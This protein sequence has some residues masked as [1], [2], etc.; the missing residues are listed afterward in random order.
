MM[1]KIKREM[2]EEIDALNAELARVTEVLEGQLTDA[3]EYGVVTE[4]AR[5]QQQGRAEAAEALAAQ[6]ATER[7]GFSKD[8]SKTQKALELETVQREQ[9][10]R[11]LDAEMKQAAPL[12]AQANQLS[13]VKVELQ[14]TQS[15]ANKRA[16][17]LLE[18]RDTNKRLDRLLKSEEVWSKTFKTALNACDW[19][20]TNAVW[21][22]KE[23]AA[24]RDGFES[25]LKDKEVMI[26][27]LEESKRKKE[28]EAK[29]HDKKLRAQMEE[30]DANAK[31]ATDAKKAAEKRVS[32]LGGSL[33][34]R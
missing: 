12:R 3:R 5:A 27:Q 6:T 4:E 25:E 30:T 22:C 17:E 29:E 31:K 26:K 11:Q 18:E 34:T 15:L 7:D 33:R 21:A 32:E 1:A 20:V 14:N 2:Q 13:T 28:A 16:A 23:V 9:V 19:E 10:Q 24:A 8:L